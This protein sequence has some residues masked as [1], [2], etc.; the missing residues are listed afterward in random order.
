MEY[1]ILGPLEV[2]EE[3]G[4][5]ALGTVKERLV[6]AVLLLHANEFVS[7]DRLIDELWGESPPPT[8]KKAVNVYI[9]KLRRTLTHDGHDPI[10]TAD[11]GYRLVV[12][13]DQLDADA[14]AAASRRP[15]SA[16]R[17]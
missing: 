8:A 3:G 15:A 7:R 6:L 13:S 16:C 11:G 2:V 4:P 1:R 14:C 12:D 9:S 17:R 5:V 10:P